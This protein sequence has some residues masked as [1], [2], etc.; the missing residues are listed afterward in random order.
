MDEKQIT[1]EQGGEKETEGRF[2]EPIYNIPPHP[3]AAA[4]SSRE[5]AIPG[6]P[7]AAEESVVALIQRAVDGLRSE[8]LEELETQTRRIQSDLQAELLPEL[9]GGLE[10]NA[11][12]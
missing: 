2:E 9:K 8:L 5:S 1:P 12:G 6:E 7:V 3:A 4:P 10:L 11:K